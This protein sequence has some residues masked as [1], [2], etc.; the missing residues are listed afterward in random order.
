MTVPR[1][2]ESEIRVLYFG[3]HLPVGTI[4]AQLG[5][6]VDVVRRV[7]GLLAPRLVPSPRPRL[8]DPVRGVI[9]ELLG[10]YPRLRATRLFDMVRPRG[11]RGSVRTLRDHVRLV[12][13]RPQREAFLRL[14][15]LRVLPVSVF[16]SRRTSVSARA[17]IVPV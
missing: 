10:R 5:V 15:M 3:E 14:S 9:E 2:V 11:Y 17:T 16:A 4:A 8:V 1:E 13:P 12:R 6:H 7:A